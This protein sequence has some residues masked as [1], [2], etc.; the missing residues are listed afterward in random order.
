MASARLPLL[1]LLGH[2][3]LHAAAR[4][5]SS[6]HDAIVDEANAVNYEDVE[7]LVKEGYD[8]NEKNANGQTPLMVA[9]IMGAED[10]V[11]QLC[12]LA[13]EPLLQDSRGGTAMHMA[14]AFGHD[15]ILNILYAARG[16]QA[17]DIADH[18][19]NTP[20]HLAARA[21]QSTVVGTLLRFG[22]DTKA[23][24]KT[25]ATPEAV[26][27]SVYAQKLHNAEKF[28]EKKQHAATVKLLRNALTTEERRALLAQGGR[29][30]PG[31][32]PVPEGSSDGAPGSKTSGSKRKRGK[33]ARVK[34]E[35]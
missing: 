14:A 19:G 6:I 21:G 13:A 9:A 25:G 29:D 12:M 34:E 31:P 23:K 26:A 32:V 10:L 16:P 8:V 35:V 17:L 24:D 27:K 2:G 1:L 18:L 4:R 20:L 5:Y 22:A 7:K 3:G 33:G 30:V 11:H 15:K 28:A